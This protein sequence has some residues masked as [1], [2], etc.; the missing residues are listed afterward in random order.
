V[1]LVIGGIDVP[2]VKGGAEG[3]SLEL[4]VRVRE[5]DAVTVSVAVWVAVSVT[6]CGATRG[7]EGVVGGVVAVDGAGSIWRA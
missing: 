2:V 6:V 5:G 3:V 7:N 1:L 4:G